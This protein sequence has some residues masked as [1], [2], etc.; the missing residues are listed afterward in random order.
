MNAD[1]HLPPHAS[2]HATTQRGPLRRALETR[3]WVGNFDRPH[4]HVRLRATDGTRLAA[5]WVPA[6]RPT[7]RAV[8]VAHGFAAN[9]RKPSYVRLAEHLAT[10]TSVLSVDLRGHGGS[11]GRCTL[12]DAEAADVAGAVRWA[13]LA[14]HAH[15]TALGTSMGATAALGAAAGRA[16]AAGG[17]PDAVVVISGPAW[18][19]DPPDTEPLQRLHA[20]WRSPVARTA[21]RYGLGVDL[22]G[23]VGWTRPPHP[24][25]L[26]AQVRSPLLVVH[27]ADDAYFPP[28][29]A[30]ALAAA[31]DGVVWHEP[32]GFGHAEDGFLPP[33]LQRLAVAVHA[34]ADDDVFTQRVD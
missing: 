34:V 14:G 33:F 7:D 22:A 27:G 10:D 20:L 9:R 5:T 32:A 26:A 11:D 19:R 4:D 2:A 12:G 24:V 21:L 8:V 6:G 23:P 15:V 28:G 29:D 13:R 16:S 18:Y 17:R 25:D 3:G 30:D 1:V 31:A